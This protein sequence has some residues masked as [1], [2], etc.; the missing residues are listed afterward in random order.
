MFNFVIRSSM[1]QY[2][3]KI[4]KKQNLKISKQHMQQ[5]LLCFDILSCTMIPNCYNIYMDGQE[6][7]HAFQR[8]LIHSIWTSNDQVMTLGS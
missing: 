2:R 7:S 3:L 8:Y 5:H 6:T 4:K 1:S